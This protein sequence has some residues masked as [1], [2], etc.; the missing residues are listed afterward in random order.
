MF[1]T[2][3]HFDFLILDTL[4]AHTQCAFLDVAMPLIS[5][6]G[7][8][9]FLWLFICALLLFTKKYRKAG[10]MVL[11]GLVI[12]FLFGNLLLKPLIARPRPC[13]LRPEVSLLISCPTDFSFP[14]GHTLS[15][16][17]AAFLLFKT[18]RTFGALAI[19]VAA[20]I[21]FSRLYLY[22]HFPSDILGAIL[23]SA[24]ISFVVH[25]L[26]QKIK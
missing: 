18:H 24:L 2:I 6:L 1:E 23:L 10:L 25:R 4:R 13:W 22:V 8:G 5:A 26:F 15:S 7:N 16:F 21:A 3:T 17:T 11:V 9:G 19:P 12:G 20:L 14:S